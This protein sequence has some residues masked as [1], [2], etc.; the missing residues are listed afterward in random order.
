MKIKKFLLAI[1]VLSIISQCL[2]FPASAESIQKQGEIPE[3]M[4]PNTIIEFTN[5]STYVIIK[6]GEYD[7][8]VEFTEVPV[9]DNRTQEE[10][11][12]TNAFDEWSKWADSQIIEEDIINIEPVKPVAGMVVT[13]ADDGYILNIQDNSQSVLSQDSNTT[14][15]YEIASNGTYRWGA[16][17]NTLQITNTY[18]R[19]TGRFTNFTD[20][21]GQANHRLVKG[22]VATK[23]EYDNC[24]L[25]QPLICKANGYTRT[26]YKWDVGG[27]P[28]AIL[29]IWKT[30]VE[31]FGYTWSSNLS[32]NNGEYCY[33]R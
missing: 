6:G 18:V 9:I 27:M 13:Y 20:T 28:D 11:E 21:I 32:I 16:H 15:A 26:M 5:D 4:A 31:C 30:G 7:T 19:G 14:R 3:R 12:A 24:I 29:D 22:D 25:G 17:N 2:F 23:M 10:I 33:Y 1:L 8:D